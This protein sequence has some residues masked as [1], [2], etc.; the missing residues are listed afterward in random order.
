MLAAGIFVCA[1]VPLQLATA[2]R[3]PAWN[4]EQFTLP[5]GLRVTLNAD[6]STSIV[7]ANVW[8]RVGS[9]NEVPGR[10]GLAHLLEHLMFA[11][12]P[13]A[14]RGTFDELLEDAGARSNASTTHDRTSYFEWMPSNVL[15]LA[16]WLEADRMQALVGTIDSATFHRQLDIV[17]N[18]RRETVDG[19][20]DGRGYELMLGALFPREHPYAWHPVGR[21]ADLDSLTLHDVR[22]FARLY[23]VPA[24]AELV[25]TGS[26]D[27]DSARALVQQYFGAIAGVVSDSSVTPRTLVPARL[28]E[29]VNIVAPGDPAAPALFMGWHT[30]PAFSDDDAALDIVARLLAHDELGRLSE[31]SGVAPRV[32]QAVSVA[33]YS[34]RQVGFL[35]ISIFLAPG[36]AP[37][38]A[39]RRVQREIERLARDGPTALELREA[40]GAMHVQLLDRHADVMQRAELLNYYSFYAGG[41]AHAEA[42][43]ARYASVSA[44]DVQRVVRRYLLA[45]HARVSIGSADASRS[46][47]V[48][49]HP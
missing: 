32:A 16:L 1:L 7:A 20:I 13:N 39:R 42:D 31:L 38:A 10:T 24:N 5:N 21:S 30:V 4:I 25:V 40:R 41:P 34:A 48:P 35:V 33:H 22:E 26:F 3:A 2:Q 18:E 11:G 44:T 12:T 46:N 49:V 47:A 6:P 9:A 8:Y 45:P 28:A 17:R 27:R 37:D 36:A 14:P 19:A 29:H 43:Q 23:Y 15:P